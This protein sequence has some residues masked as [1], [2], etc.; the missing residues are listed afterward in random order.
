MRIAILT[1]GTRGDTQ[2][3]VALGIGLQR[4]GHQVR[5]AACLNFESF[6]QQYGLDYYPIRSDLSAIMSSELAQTVMATKNPI[7][8]LAVQAQA[9]KTQM[10]MMRDVQEDTWGA[11][12]DAD[13]ILFSPGLPNA[14]FVARQLGVPCVALNAV[15]MMPTRMEPAAMFYAGPRLGG[16]YNRVTH[17][18]QEQMFWQ[19]FRP[20]IQ[21]FW[22]KHDQRVRIPFAAPNGRQRREGLLTLY[23]YSEH[24]L[25]RPK[26]WSES[27]YVTGYWFLDDEPAWTPPDSLIHFLRSGP[28]P[29]YIGFGSMGNP[30]KA[31]EMTELSLKAL[32]LSGQRGILATGWNGMSGDRHLPETAYVLESAPHSWLFPQMLAVVHHG[33]AGTSAAGVR[34]GVPSII[35]PHAVDQPMWG[36]RI[37]ELG[38]GPEPI[39]RKLL[40]AE[41]LA[42]AI[43]ATTDP[44][45][46][47]RAT[48]LGRKV[49]AENGVTR[50]IE[51]LDQRIGL[52]V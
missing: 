47:A 5:L 21:Y 41:R 14:Y 31:A 7:K 39:P 33:G 17:T 3:Y 35:V 29:V 32:E 6:V 4:A 24:V 8:M 2:P 45:I 40:S 28:P 50:A 46:R 49:R 42:Q 27:T 37:A 13:L 16:V 30:R 52:R 10:P 19:S 38:V 36:R 23:G 25:P 34:A 1:A 51:I 48:D 43:R 22:R 44:S 18:I 26:D 20:A 12:Q 15:P 11:C 9:L